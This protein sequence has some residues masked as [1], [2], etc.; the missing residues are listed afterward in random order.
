MKK[1]LFVCSDIHSAFTPWMEAL[2][3]AGFDENN[4]E[5]MIVVCGDLFDR[6]DETKEVYE[7]AL[8]MIKRGKLVY[9]MGNHDLLMR[10]MLDRG[11]SLWYDT[12]NGTEKTFYHLLN[13]YSEKT[14]ENK[15]D[16]EI[17][18]ELLQPLYSRMVNYFKT[19]HYIF[20]HGFLPVVKQPDGTYKINRHWRR[21]SREN[22][23]NATWLNGME[24]AH[25]GLY[26]KNKTIV[27]GHWHASWARAEFEDKPE[28]GDGA[29]FS[30][31]YYKDKLIAIDACTAYSGKVNVLVLEDELLEDSHG[32]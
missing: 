21:A 23:E 17:V 9:C 25:N 13:M 28:F 4:N 30:P 8:D 22:W 32:N 19:K 1:K 24:M 10:S 14:N 29:D 7:F 11:F 20:C 31:Y 12:H 6:L 16:V 5:H 18:N 26:L 2:N 27:V 3:K 15:T